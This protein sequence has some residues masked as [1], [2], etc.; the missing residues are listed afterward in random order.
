MQQI[1]FKKG[2]ALIEDIPAPAASKGTVLIQV[3]Y[4]C[5]STGTEMAGLHQ[6]SPP[7]GF[8]EK[9]LDINNIRKGLKALF[10]EGPT[11]MLTKTKGVLF[12]TSPVKEEYPIELPGRPGGYSVSGIIIAKGEDVHEFGIGDL[13]AAAGSSANHA[14]FVEV[15]TKLVVP[16]PADMDMSQASTVAIGSIALH[17]IR[18]ADLQL[19]EFAVVVGAGLI[20]LL[21]VQLLK[22]MGIRVIAVDLDENRLRLA[23]EYGAEAT[24]N[25]L[26]EDQVKV[27]SKVTG[28]NFADAVLFTA[29]T[30]KS[31]PLSLA[32]QMCKRK[33]R[34]V[35]VGV[36][37]MTIDRQDIYEKELDF[38]ISTSYGPG[39]YDKQYEIEG[40]DYPYAYVRWT[41]NRNM[42]E[43][44][45]L[46]YNKTVNLDMMMA[47]P[48]PIS[49]ALQAYGA[50]KENTNRP[51]IVTIEY[52]HVSIQD[53]VNDI[54]QL[55]K[56]VFSNKVINKDKAGVAI[57]GPGSFAMA[58]HVPHLKKLQNLCT[59]QAV[60]SR[61]GPTAKRA[62]IICDA[63]YGTTSIEDILNDPEIDVV[64]ISTRHDSHAELA[65]RALD[66]GKHVFLEKPLATDRKG[67]ELITDFYSESSPNQIKP[68]L[69]VGFNRRFSKYA[70]EIKKHVEQRNGPIMAIY[71]MNAGYFPEE[72]WVHKD[73]GRI[74]GEACHIIDL[75]TYFTGAKIQ[76]ISCESITPTHGKYSKSDNKAISLKYEDGSVCTIHYFSLGHNTFPK[77]Y[78][79]IHFDEKTIVLDNYQSLKGYGVD[80]EEI[81]TEKSEKGHL[82]ELEI[83]LEAVKVKSENWPIPLWDMV[84]TT[85]ATVLLR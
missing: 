75:M 1:M 80:L 76:S 44:L 42:K 62:A 10:H 59:I 25:P 77:E 85:E 5:I 63:R 24:V 6:P 71:R 72:H 30:K 82:E 58:V 31:D 46:V 12:P 38:L 36:A 45:R 15:P 51:L 79:E 20:G 29:A 83:F 67:I 70:Q 34:V 37:G 40:N 18:R 19:G 68:L 7:K 60:M 69:M 2:R 56:S 28:G 16:V 52:S 66:A 64:L 23:K 65:R 78:L 54:K 26:A 61:T 43:Y 4:S 22:A 73:G 11:K 33:G 8:K 32:F 35:L 50:L 57:V 47:K 74:I 27:V 84:Q 49:E 21:T 13:V 41:E 9:A 81:I 48:Y 3:L 17:G 14:E 55:Q 53:P 39:R